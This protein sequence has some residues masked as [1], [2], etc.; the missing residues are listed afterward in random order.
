MTAAAEKV[1][2]LSLSGRMVEGEHRLPLRIYYEDTDAGG[3]VYYARYLQFAERARTEIL[4]LAGIEQSALRGSHDVVFAVSRCEVRYRRPARLDD[5]VEVRSRLVG[6]RGAK[7]S[8]VQGVWR[9]GEE[10]VRLAVDVASVRGDG[11]PTR[12]PAPVRAALEPFVQQPFDP[13]PF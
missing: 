3:I 7:L 1:S 12:I 9:G 6:L 8:A 13:Q 4:R 11:R 5:L 2:G 10:L